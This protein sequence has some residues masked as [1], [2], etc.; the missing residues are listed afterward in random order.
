MLNKIL[1]NGNYYIW[2]MQWKTDREKI[3]KVIYDYCKDR[4]TSLDSDDD[5]FKELLGVESNEDSRH[6]LQELADELDDKVFRIKQ[7]TQFGRL[8]VEKCNG[9]NEFDYDE[10]VESLKPII[11]KSKKWFE[12]D[13]TWK[14]IPT[15][16]AMVFGLL[17]LY[18]KERHSILSNENESLR[19]DLKFQMNRAD[20]L[21][22]EL[23][24]EKESQKAFLD[25]VHSI[26]NEKTSDTLIEDSVYK[27]VV[28]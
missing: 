3:V 17:N 19:F 2:R 12:K 13:L 1:F 21:S 6:I 18:Q 9:F 28:P 5:D 14:I 25:S 10:W 27:K 7:K 16:A 11:P 8:F 4:N 20:S 23:T 22:S 26:R 15:V 24:K